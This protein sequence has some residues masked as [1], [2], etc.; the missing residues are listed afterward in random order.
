MALQEVDPYSGTRLSEVVVGY[1][2]A[3]E[4]HVVDLAGRVATG[5]EA[6]LAILDG[7]P[8]G[9]LLRPWAAVPLVRWLV[10]SGYGWVATNRASIG[11]WFGLE[12]ACGAS[13]D[14]RAQASSPRSR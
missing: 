10:G 1:A 7:L 6:A 14:G 8:G 5:G 4:L 13:V 12:L 11:R 2:L 3:D 9:R